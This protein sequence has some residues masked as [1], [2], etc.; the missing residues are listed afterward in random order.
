M[1][2]VNQLTLLLIFQPFTEHLRLH[3][4]GHRC[5]NLVFKVYVFE[6]AH[7]KLQNLH[8]LFDVYLLSKCQIV[9]ED[10]VMF[11]LAFLENMN[12]TK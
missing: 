7:K 4:G 12:F 6:E 3:C 11:F 8:R 2:F 1:A 5:C 10:F 9:G